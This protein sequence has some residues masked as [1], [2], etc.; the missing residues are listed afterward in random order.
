M[1]Q[2]QVGCLL[3]SS[4]PR[5]GGRNT[6]FDVAGFHTIERLSFSTRQEDW[7]HTLEIPST[8][9]AYELRIDPKGKFSISG[10][11]GSQVLFDLLATGERLRTLSTEERRAQSVLDRSAG[12]LRIQVH[13]EALFARAEKGAPGLNK[14]LGG[15]ATLLVGNAP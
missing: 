3:E 12:N 11:D 5:R 13:I 2:Q 8:G 10:A 4:G 15:T 7:S 9:E 14:L 1:D 6:K